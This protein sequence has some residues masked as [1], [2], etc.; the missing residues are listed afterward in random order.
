MFPQIA[1][2][3]APLGVETPGGMCPSRLHIAEVTFA[4]NPM[5]KQS[6]AQIQD[7]TD[8]IQPPEASEPNP[9]P[10]RNPNPNPN[11]NLTLTRTRTPTLTPNASAQ[12]GRRSDKSSTGGRCATAD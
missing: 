3:L 6:V 7:I 1:T 2:A 10:N 12:G 11:P 8:R 5:S 4:F 9:N